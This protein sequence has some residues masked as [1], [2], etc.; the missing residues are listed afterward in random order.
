M[1]DNG[2]ED[3]AASPEPGRAKRAPPTIDLTASVV[4][5]ESSAGEGETRGRAVVPLAGGGDIF[6]AL[7][8]G[9]SAAVAAVLVIAV[10]WLSGW[11][12]SST[13]PAL[14]PETSAAIES[15]GARVSSIE[16]KAG[17]AAPAA[18]DPRVDALEKSADALRGELSSLRAQ[19]DRQAATV[20]DL[21]SA[22]RESAAA[23]D[24]S[25]INDRIAG[26]ERSL[27]AQADAARTSEK[28][29]DDP[30]LRLMVV[31]SL[32]DLHVRQGEPFAAALSAAKSLGAH[33]DALK[34]LD[35]FAATGV[36]G[37][38]ALSRELLALVPKLSPPA[39]QPA[40]TGSGLIDRLEAGAARLVRIERLDTPGG[41]RSAVLARI[42]AAAQR[43][44]VAAARAELNS[45]AA[46]DRTAAQGWIDR[47]EARDTA[48]AASRQFAEAAMAAL[49]NPAR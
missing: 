9:A 29:A 22:P 41:D 48:L 31:A 37:A 2:P 14:S 12:A 25:A 30:G 40:T 19:V 5:D 44:D 28:P 33:A 32:L 34:P 4:S 36:P 11:G 46:A 26:I 35:A 23:P 39:A 18:P 3:M 21:K 1:V 27:R 15:L 6:L 20:N 47:S 43:N 45:L 8:A 10:A 49:A 24:L 38:A 42:T 13:P 7:I 17:S 16:S